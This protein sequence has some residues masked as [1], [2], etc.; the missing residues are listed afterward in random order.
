MNKNKNGFTLIEM[1]AVIAIIA[2]LVAI[3]VPAIS[4][5][6]KKAQA[7]VDAA[8]LRS[9]LG[10]LNTELAV[11]NTD[12]A[13]TVESLE[14]I[15]SKCFD[16]AEIQILY[17]NPGFIKI[18]YVDNTTYYSLDYFSAVAEGKSVEGISTSKPSDAGT[19]YKAG[20]ADPLN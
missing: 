3:I 11:T 15:E 20:S 13:L 14:Q 2:V 17:T 10:L 1:L 18:F 6:T 8:N 16:N 19:W 5:S 7:S 12:V 9:V 4:G